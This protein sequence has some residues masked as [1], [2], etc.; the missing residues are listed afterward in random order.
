MLLSSELPNGVNSVQ[1][2]ANGKQI[3]PPIKP[4]IFIS[5][6]NNYYEYAIGIKCVP[7]YLLNSLQYSLGDKTYEILP[8]YNN[9][10]ME[11]LT[12]TYILEVEEPQS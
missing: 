1:V 3:F 9:M 11:N 4:P 5:K 12:S 8:Y 10:T 7:G 2:V 6:V